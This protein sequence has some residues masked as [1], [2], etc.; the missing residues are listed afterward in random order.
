MLCRMLQV[1]RSGYYDWRVRRPSRRTRENHRLLVKIRAFHQASR[2]TYGAPR[3]H[4]DLRADGEYCG[5]HRVARLMRINGIQARTM[6]RFKT[7]T[8]S[9]PQLPAA[10]NLLARRF[11][12]AAPNQRWVSDIT[13][14]KTAESRLYLAV[15]LEWYSR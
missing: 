10:G 5:R 8:D 6:R 7:T 9:G 15:V 13:Y 4:A 1:S 11:T 12:V 14:L 2:K 3:I